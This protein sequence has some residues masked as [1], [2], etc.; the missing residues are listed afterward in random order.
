M[1]SNPTEVI[2]PDFIFQDIDK[3]IQ[4]AVSQAYSNHRGKLMT[5]SLYELA[6]N[7]INNTI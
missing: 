7:N 3:T 6:L 5:A 4:N 1:M 2:T